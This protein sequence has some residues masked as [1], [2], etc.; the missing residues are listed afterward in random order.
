M[1]APDRLWKKTSFHFR[2]F[3]HQRVG[4]HAHIANDMI[5]TRCMEGWTYLQLFYTK[6]QTTFS[7][8]RRYGPSLTTCVCVCVRVRV[9]VRVCG[10]QRGCLW[11][12]VCMFLFLCLT[13]CFGLFNC[14]GLGFL[15][16]DYFHLCI[17][18]EWITCVVTVVFWFSLELYLVL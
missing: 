13:L 11:V 8:R 5:D 7:W 2:I 18:L 12:Y 3:C 15:G 4:S 1:G 16:R 17:R 10:R 6:S 9:C 14:S